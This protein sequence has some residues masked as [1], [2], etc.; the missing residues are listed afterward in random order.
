M[1]M[2]EMREGGRE[3]E[4]RRRWEEEEEEGGRLKT[5]AAG[6]GVRESCDLRR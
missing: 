3:E 4:C 6:E 5:K 1:I 2:G